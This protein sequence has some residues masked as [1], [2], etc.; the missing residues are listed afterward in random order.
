MSDDESTSTKQVSII[1][2]TTEPRKSVLFSYIDQMISRPERQSTDD[3]EERIINT[4]SR[5]VEDIKNKCKDIVTLVCDEKDWKGAIA[6]IMCLCTESR[7]HEYKVKRFESE[8]RILQ[9][10]KNIMEL[11]MNSLRD[12]IR[13]I[14]RSEDTERMRWLLDNSMALSNNWAREAERVEACLKEIDEIGKHFKFDDFPADEEVSEGE[15]GDHICQIC[16]G[17]KKQA[18]LSCG[19]EL[20][21][22]CA[23]KVWDDKQECPFCK[24][25]LICVIKRHV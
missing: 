4:L 17:K 5:D 25:F 2:T 24:E 12:R 18:T 22:T 6:K 10:E 3:T 8:M 19:H 16:C 23:G 20:C 1:R 14:T 7:Q 11:E 21:A 15:E 9:N 13:S